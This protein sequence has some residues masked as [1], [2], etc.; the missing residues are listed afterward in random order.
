MSLALIAVLVLVLGA[1]VTIT[2]ASVLGVP[3]STTHTISTSI[4]GVGLAHGPG[5]VR[6][7]IARRLVGGD[8]R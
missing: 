7:Q 4:M 6:W 1:G 8:G 5:A 2:V 3:L